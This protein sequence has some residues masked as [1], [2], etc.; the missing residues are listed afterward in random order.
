MRAEIDHKWV[1]DL[2]E[3]LEVDPDTT[4]AVLVDFYGVYVQSYVFDENGLMM[5]RGDEPM[6]SMQSRPVIRPEQ[7]SDLSET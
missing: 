3:Y 2:C 1:L 7:E 5:M 4:K 6:I